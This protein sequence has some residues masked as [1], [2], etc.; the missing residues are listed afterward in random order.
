MW[1]GLLL[2]LVWMGCAPRT[3]VEVRLDNGSIDN[4]VDF[5]FVELGQTQER[6]LT[7]ASHSL[8]LTLTAVVRLSGDPVRLLPWLDEPDAVFRFEPELLVLGQGLHVLYDPPNVAE[9]TVHEAQLS[10]HFASP[11]GRTLRVPLSLRGVAMNFTCGTPGPLDFGAVIAG[12][13]AS[14]DYPFNNWRDVPDVVSFVPDIHFSNAFS[15]DDL[16]PSGPFTLPPRSEHVAHLTFTPR[17]TESFSATVA[18]TSSSLCPQRVLN[19]TGA[20]VPSV[21]FVTGSPDFPWAPLA[22][23]PTANIR[24]ENVMRRPVVLTRASLRGGADFAWPALPL[25]VPAASTAADGTVVAGKLDLPITFTPTHEGV[26]EDWLDLVT[27]LP[28]QALISV[29]L[30]GRA[31]QPRA[32]LTPATLSLPASPAVAG[33]GTLTLTNVG[34]LSDD[35]AVSLRVPASA[36]WALRSL[37]GA[38][39]SEVCVGEWEGVNNRCPGTLDPR[40]ASGLQRGEQLIIPVRIVPTSSG[41]RSFELTLFTN[42][43][44]HPSLVSTLEVP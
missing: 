28:A 30:R 37:T 6:G 40:G 21:L 9:E 17:S 23:H 5:G 32:E 33:T 41:P 8:P 36:P 38:P 44:D 35:P 15:V 39:L 7:L 25:T 11:D 20:G 43:P 3:E 12:R 10:L 22:A 26:L 19:V 29:Q 42:D 34:T 24:L 13:Q 27:D 2:S 4:S 16:T 31:G 14:L 1:R 18:I